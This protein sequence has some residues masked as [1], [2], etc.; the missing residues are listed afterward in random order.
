MNEKMRKW[1][2]TL[3]RLIFS[4]VLIYWL[5]TFVDL[6]DTINRLQNTNLYGLFVAACLFVSAMFIFPIRW[7]VLL[8]AFGFKQIKYLSLVK[9]YWIGLFFNNFLPTSVGGDIIRAYYI[10]HDIQTKGESFASVVIER[11]LGFIV[12]SAISLI[13]ILFLYDLFSVKQLTL[14]AVFLVLF[15]LFLYSTI[16][17]DSF[18]VFITHWLEKIKFFNVGD[19]FEQ[20]FFA[21]RIFNKNPEI[22]LKALLF[23]A[24]GQLLIILF[25]AA[26]YFAI[27]GKLDFLPFLIVIPLTIIASLF[28]SING[29]GTRETAYV[30]L[31]ALFNIPKEISFALAVFVFI[32]PLI[33]SL[34]GGILYTLNPLKLRGVKWK[35]QKA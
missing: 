17:V 3:L 13:S 12:T 23:T 4:I 14:L 11:M 33:V 16:M 25:N 30:M 32:L 19:K 5:L 2:G 18:F 7:R 8:S 27:T 21:F 15:I 20:I 29:L 34:F 24:F 9:Y 26:I 6:K 28:P 31:L 1:G 22:L 35:E 10:S